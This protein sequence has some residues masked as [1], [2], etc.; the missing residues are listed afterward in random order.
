MWELHLVEDD[1]GGGT[2]GVGVMMCVA[3]GIIL[4]RLYVDSCTVLGNFWTMPTNPPVTT[5]S[6]FAQI[7]TYAECPDGQ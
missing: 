4:Q 5:H 2:R 6:A 1:D 7:T 3:G